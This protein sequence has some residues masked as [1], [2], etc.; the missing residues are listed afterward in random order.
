MNKIWI[1]KYKKEILGKFENKIDVALENY[2]ELHLFL[3]NAQDIPEICNY[4]YGNLGTRLTTV[5]CT[6]ERKLGNGFVIRHVFGKENGEDVFIFVTS[7]IDESI[8]SYPSIAMA[9]PAATL[10]E[11]EIHDMFGIIPIDNPDTR[12]LVLHDHWDKNIFPLRKD[13]GLNTKIPR[14]ER[15]YPFLKVQGEGIC[16]IPVG[17]VHAGIIE[18]GHFRFSVMGENIINLET[19][20][21][22]AHKGIE[23]LAESMKIDDVLLLSERIAG[24]ESI[25][26]ST[27]FCQSIEK[28]ASVTIP[29]RAQQI[30]TIFGELERLYNHMGSLA[31]ISMD[32]G[33]PFGSSRLNILKERLMKLNE[34]LSGSRILFGVNRIG[35]VRCNITDESKKIITESMD[36]I[37]SDFENIVTL[38]KSKSSFIDRLKDT[39]II[40]KRAAQDLGLVGVAARCIGIDV[41]T[42]RDHPYS[43]Y[44]LHKKETPH[45][46]MQR[47][48]SM[49]KRN[50]DVLTRFEVRV[51][52]VLESFDIIRASLNL[53][54]DS[55]YVNRPQNLE[56]F[57]SALGYTESHRGQTVH[58]VM[59]GENNSIFRYKVRTASF[60]N[61][62]II[63]QSVLNDIVPD[64]PLVNKSLDL[65]YSG[66]DL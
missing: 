13:F 30:R 21:F 42:R 33:F 20:L 38:L 41:D 49:Q 59:T 5:I 4:I 24:D 53:E 60:F 26:N 43:S 37:L 35:G 61:W 19:R 56:P 28:I 12:P 1:E 47:E 52:E 32:V 36:F 25:A 57:R 17:P 62:P 40:P 18:P 16:E 51:Q 11:R 22:Y 7:K 34:S 10:H 8:L 64:F 46:V 15:E 3:K 23:K 50:G 9:I 39:G 44:L 29:K 66:N 54:N 45:E 27:A 63:E 2:N 48:I 55:L 31:G 14:Q 65:S 58:W 6:D